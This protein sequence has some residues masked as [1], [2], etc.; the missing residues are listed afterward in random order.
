MERVTTHK[1][2]KSGSIVLMHNGGKFTADAL[3]RVIL[4][5]KEQGYEIVPLSRMIYREGYHMNRDGRQVKD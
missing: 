1:N 2:L 4:Q 3:E 5:L